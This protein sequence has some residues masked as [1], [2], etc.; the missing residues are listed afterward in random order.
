VLML[1]CALMCAQTVWQASEYSHKHSSQHCCGLC[2]AEPLPYLQADPAP[3]APVLSVEWLNG[4][5][6]LNAMRP[7]PIAEG[8]SRAPPA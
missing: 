4:S 8:H 1:L 3:F 7:A 6:D 2:H 5:P